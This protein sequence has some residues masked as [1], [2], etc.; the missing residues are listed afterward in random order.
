MLEDL[1]HKFDLRREKKEAEL[2]TLSE[3]VQSI[4]RESAT[5]AEAIDRVNLFLNNTTCPADIAEAGMQENREPL[6]S[7]LDSLRDN[8][9]SMQQR[10]EGFKLKRLLPYL[11]AIFHLRIHSISGLS[12]VLTKIIWNLH[13]NL[14]N[15]YP[16]IR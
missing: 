4:Q 8:I 5:L 11:R 7:I 1:K 15:L 16:T 2:R 9:G 6:S 13:P 3:N 10:M 14:T 12:S